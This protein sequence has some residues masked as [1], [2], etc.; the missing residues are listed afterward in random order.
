MLANLV[1][2]HGLIFSQRVL[3]ELMDKGLKRQK[4]YDLVQRCAM[5][6][7]KDGSDFKNN[8]LADAEVTRHLTKKELDKIFDLDYYLRNVN[9][10]FKRVGL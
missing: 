1:R 4:A 10:I 8:L 7:W 6:S 3:L 5:K 9:K 2:T